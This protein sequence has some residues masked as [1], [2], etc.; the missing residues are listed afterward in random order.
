MMVCDWCRKNLRKLLLV[1]CIA[2]KRAEVSW[3]KYACSHLLVMT[4]LDKYL[5]GYT[6]FEGI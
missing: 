4:S 1:M 2:P 5:K 3:E 6:C